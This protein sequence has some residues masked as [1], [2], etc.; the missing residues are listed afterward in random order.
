MLQH[1]KYIAIASGVFY[2]SGAACVDYAAANG[3]WTTSGG[4]TSCGEKAYDLLRKAEDDGLSAVDFRFGV[5][6]VEKAKRGQISFSEAEK[7]LNDAV[8]RYISQIR[9]GRFDPKT[10]DHRIVMRPDHVD[11]A[12]IVSQGASSGSCEWLSQQEPPY[13]G[14]KQLKPLLKKYRA[15]ASQGK[16]PQLP[17]R[18][19]VRVGSSDENLPAVREML[20][21]LG[22]LSS[23]DVGGGSDYDDAL[24]EGV[25]RFQATHSLLAD[26]QIG[27]VTVKELNKSPAERVRQIVITME[28]WRWMPRNPGSRH[29]KVNIAGFQLEGVENGRIVLRSPII[30]G[31]DYRETP[32]FTAPMTEVKFNPSWHVPYNLAIKDKLPKIK[33][34]PSYLTKNH[35]VLTRTVN[36]REQEISPHSVNWGSVHAGNFN[37]NLRQTPGDH[38]A[39]GRIRFTILS[40]FDIFLHSTPDQHLFDYPIRTFSSGC[41]RV[42][43]VAELGEFA[44]NNPSVWPASRIRQEMQGSETKVMKLPQSIPVYV[45]YFTV[46]TDENGESHFMTDVYGQDK[47]VESAM[48]RWL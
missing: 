7:Q 28:R 3:L 13:E 30:V 29:I 5:E 40:P 27:P 4:L 1:V 46:W 14:Y 37:F 23:S 22:Y 41:I 39:L 12:S 38:N 15:L 32:V 20:A 48:K 25:K 43:K 10:V 44:M 8:L 11:P 6:A 16:W 17:A 42:K 33:E 31:T 47:H 45:T 21:A 19:N 9:N 2:L 24:L 26:G 36:G 35:F 34:D 18:M